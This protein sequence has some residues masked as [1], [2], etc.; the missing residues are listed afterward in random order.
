MD[1]NNTFVLK[2]NELFD[3]V[4]DLQK[5]ISAFVNIDLSKFF[6]PGITDDVL[7]ISQGSDLAAEM[8]KSMT[9]VVELQ[10]K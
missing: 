10:T 1:G 5:E 4:K 7:L 2:L 3:K 8:K 9:D 6:V